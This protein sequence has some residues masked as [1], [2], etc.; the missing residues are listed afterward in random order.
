MTENGKKKG[1]QRFRVEQIVAGSFG[2]IILI[3]FLLLLLP[4]SHAPGET[5]HWTDALFTAVSA[6]C[7]T[8]LV[9][10]P[11][12]LHWSLFGKCVILVLIQLGGLGIL[13]CA[14]ATLLLLGRRL[15]MHTQRLIAENYNLDTMNGLIGVIRKIVGGTLLVEAVGT[16][17]Y[18]VVFIPEYGFSSG[19]FRAVFN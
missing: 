7:V 5:T 15:S 1:L 16:L 17:P 3:G 12:A 4:I 18:A 14:T 19:L 2:L 6:V 9:T 8:G 13:A 10:V 11:T